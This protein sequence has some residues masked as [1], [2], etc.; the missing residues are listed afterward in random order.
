MRSVANRERALLLCLVAPAALSAA[1]AALAQ[2]AYSELPD[3]PLDSP[4]VSVGV[5]AEGDNTVS[6]EMAATW[7]TF[8]NVAG[9]NV[10]WFSFDVPAGLTVTGIEV[11]VTSQVCDNCSATANSTNPDIGAVALAGSGMYALP[12]QTLSGALSPGSYNVKLSAR[13]NNFDAGGAAIFNYRVRFTAVGGNDACADA[14]AVGLGATPIDNTDATTDGPD[15]PA[16]CNFFGNPGISKDKWYTFTPAAGG[17]LS[18]D[19]C[20]STFDTELALYTGASC[21][22]L[23][24]SI[25]ACNDDS[26]A[27]GANSRQSSLSVAVAAGQT[28]LI[29]VGGFNGASGTGTL[30]LAIT[31]N[32][33]CCNPATGGCAVDDQARCAALGCNFAGFATA[34]APATCSACPADF[35]RSGTLSVQDIFDFLAAYF[36]GCP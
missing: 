31:T 17:A 18:V 11:M 14:R 22:S 12:I 29:R 3:L 8:G 30:S 27:C 21:A 15:H 24:A 16:E 35:N 19:T 20:G 4:S 25:L 32:G 28:Y 7:D 10:D 33:A 1:P 9:D 6:G 36:A 23:T 5:L 26:A 34:C 2:V 13:R